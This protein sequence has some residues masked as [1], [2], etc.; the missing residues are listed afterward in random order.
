LRSCMAFATFLDAASLYFRAMVI[1][2]H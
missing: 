2:L 1:P